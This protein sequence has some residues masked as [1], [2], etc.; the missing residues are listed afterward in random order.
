MRPLIVADPAD[1]CAAT[2]A[3]WLMAS[4]PEA[5]RR[6]VVRVFG[7]ASCPRGWH[8]A[9]RVAHPDERVAYGA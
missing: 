6:A 2:T 9:V 7:R 4:V 3:E 8:E 5:D 1:R